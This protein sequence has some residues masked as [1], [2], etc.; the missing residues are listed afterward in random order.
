MRSLGH[1]NVRVLDGTIRDW[2]ISGKPMATETTVLPT[3]TY[4]SQFNPDFSADYNYVVSGSAQ[5]VDARTMQQF[6]EGSI[7]NAINIPYENVIVNSK[8]RD[9][10]KLDRVFAFLDKNRPVVV[11]TN[12]GLRGSVVWFAPTL[13]GYDARLYTYENWL[14]NQA[15]LGKADAT[16]TAT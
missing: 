11:Y 14:Y 1:E 2:A 10:T 9:E 4:I 5:I 12:S 15:A 3:K 8:I 6:G 7:P 16:N 13:Q